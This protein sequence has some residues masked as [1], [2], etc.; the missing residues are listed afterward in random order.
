M[1]NNYQL[2]QSDVNSTIKMV[3]DLFSIDSYI[4]I[5]LY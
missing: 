5:Y 3:K 4:K 2:L 1:L